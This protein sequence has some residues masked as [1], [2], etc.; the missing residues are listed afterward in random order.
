MIGCYK[1]L[2]LFVMVL[3]NSQQVQFNVQDSISLLRVGD[4]TLSEECPLVIDK[5]RE[6]MIT[7]QVV[8]KILVLFQSGDITGAL[9]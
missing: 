7:E 1:D 5:D 3:H 6:L 9:C 8:N 4:D 2:V